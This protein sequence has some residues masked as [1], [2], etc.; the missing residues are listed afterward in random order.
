[1]RVLE[2][3]D[4]LE[5]AILLCYRILF[6]ESNFSPDNYYSYFCSLVDFYIAAEGFGDSEMSFVFLAHFSRYITLYDWA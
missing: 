6:P 2:G 3:F 5:S 4:S 1:M